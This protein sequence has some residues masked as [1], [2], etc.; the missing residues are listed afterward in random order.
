MNTRTAAVVGLIPAAGVLTDVPLATLAA[1]LVFIAS[2][3]FHWGKLRS[4]LRFDRV[5]F[6]LAVVTLLTVAFVGVQQ[7]IA[8]AVVLAIVDRTRRSARPEAY[9]LGRIPGTTSWAPLGHSEHPVAV[10]GVLVFL[11]VAPLYYANAGHFRIQVHRALAEASSPPKLFVLDADAM[12]DFD[13]TG[14]QTL[15][16]LVDE[17]DRSHVTV[18]VARAVGDVPRNLARSDL[19]DRIGRDHVFHTV[20]EAVK[21]LAPETSH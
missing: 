10:P 5:E 17:F 12:S 14:S 6:G 11:F 19:I 9:V 18:A 13:Y 8:L 1:V 20:D 2:R 16:A 15:G 7:G 4:V 3:I 21:A